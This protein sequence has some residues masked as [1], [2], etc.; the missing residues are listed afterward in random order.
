MREKREGSIT[1]K[2]T[3]LACAM[4]KKTKLR[5]G[6]EEVGRGREH[7]MLWIGRGGGRGLALR[8]VRHERRTRE[9]GFVSAEDW[10]LKEGRGAAEPSL[11]EY[12]IP[13]GHIPWH[14]R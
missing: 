10:K 11:V 5:K 7:S 2:H 1:S 4:A 3:V 14:H 13:S 12:D 6:G 9:G 8:I